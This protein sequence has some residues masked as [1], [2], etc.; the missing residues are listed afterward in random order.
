VT[1]RRQLIDAVEVTDTGIHVVRLKR[2]F[3]ATSVSE[4]E[5]VLAYLL[6]R[7]HYRIVVD[8]TQVEFVAS[9]GWGAFTAEFRNVRHAGG[10]IR[11]AGM[12]P[13][14]QDV[15]FLLELDSFINAYEHVDEAIASFEAELALAAHN[16]AP[17]SVAKPAEAKVEAAATNDVVEYSPPASRDDAHDSGKDTSPEPVAFEVAEVYDPAFRPHLALGPGNTTPPV[18]ATDSLVPA[19]TA[20][21]AGW[22]ISEEVESEEAE[23]PSLA[24]EERSS[25]H[26]LTPFSSAAMTEEVHDFEAEPESEAF[27]LS[28]NDVET[29]PEA[30]TARTPAALAKR[31]D[32]EVA[33]PLAEEWPEVQAE[34]NVAQDDFEL[35]DIHDPWILE[36]IDTLPEEDEFDE[37]DWHE[38]ETSVDEHPIAPA[39]PRTAQA[40]ARVFYQETLAPAPVATDLRKERDPAPA[41][42]RNEAV[43]SLQPAAA[44][45]PKAKVRPP[46]LEPQPA[47]TAHET[48]S[49]AAS[50]A[51]RVKAASKAQPLQKAQNVAKATLEGDHVEMV[52]Q[53]VSAHPHYGPAMIQKFFETRLESPVQVS[54]STVYR[55]LRLAGLNTR[56]QRLEFAGKAST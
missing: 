18:P 1:N 53:I 40:S 41:K 15:F 43:D 26:A 21:E 42:L 33:R 17:A 20:E 38:H 11:L 29:W 28:E 48:Q 39:P 25:A 24:P 52:R 14:V 10:D 4:F 37:T 22:I 12:N 34:E 8:L 51:D 30:D 9:A 32:E 46:V 45:S 19:T 56:E 36:E 7:Q 23:Y 2:I 13:D 35:Q 55:W 6:S 50:L 49:V 27:A 3:D 44:P 16:A 54:R 47:P 31:T 5:K